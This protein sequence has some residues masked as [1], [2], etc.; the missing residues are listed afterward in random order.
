MGA[1]LLRLHS[2]REETVKISIITVCLNSSDTIEDTINSVLGQDYKDIEYIVIDGG[3]RDGTLDIL[4]GYKKQITKYISEPDKGI[5][6]AMNKGI[7]MAT[8]RVVGFLNADDLYYDESVISQIADTI[9]QN[10]YQAVYGDLVYVDRRKTEKVVR[11]WHAGQYKKGAF[12][13]GWVLPHPTF[14]CKR[15][16]FEQFG[17]FNEN[18]Q[19]AADFELELR[20]IEK[21]QIKI[22][23]IPKV[24]VK[25]RKGGKATLVHGIITGNKEI[26]K[27]FHMNHLKISP[28]FFI[29]RPII[30]IYQLFNRPNGSK[31]KKTDS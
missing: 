11:Y 29:L 5:Y 30:K 9:K 2:H 20:F 31:S 3:S 24:L 6:N 8:G 12:R 10:D 14:F 28:S 1:A 22:G 26:L 16:L 21:H 13:S 19:I 7:G 15:E 27:S 25:M 18:F 23:Y 17:Y 4:T